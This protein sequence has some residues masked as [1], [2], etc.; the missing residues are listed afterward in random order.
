MQSSSTWSQND[1]VSVL[2]LKR[3][4]LE[5]Q[6]K[7]QREMMNFLWDRHKSFWGKIFFSPAEC[8]VLCR[9]ATYASVGNSLVCSL[10]PPFMDDDHLN[11]WI[12]LFACSMKIVIWKISICFQVCGML[13]I[14]CSSMQPVMTGLMLWLGCYDWTNVMIRLIEKKIT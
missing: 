4:L 8:A 3:S 6:L 1:L 5:R 7:F 9:D 2:L 13:A 11:T 14:A 10:H 12:I